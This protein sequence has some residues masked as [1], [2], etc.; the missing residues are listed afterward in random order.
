MRDLQAEWDKL[1]KKF[2]FT[3]RAADHKFRWGWMSSYPFVRMCVHPTSQR[4]SCQI[5]ISGRAMMW[6]SS[7]LSTRRKRQTERDRRR[8]E[9]PQHVIAPGNDNIA[10]SEA[11][12]SCV[13]HLLQRRSGGMNAPS[14]IPKVRDDWDVLIVAS[15]VQ[16]FLHRRSSTGNSECIFEGVSDH[17]VAI[18]PCIV[19][20]HRSGWR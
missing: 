14:R 6:K 4:T 18:K 5:D 16:S 13:Q 2:A 9:L 11:W 3:M 17:Y 7:D 20:F 12:E 1:W 19:C 8:T 15:R 10:R